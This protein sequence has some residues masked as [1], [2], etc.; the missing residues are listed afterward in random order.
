[1]K[2]TIDYDPF[3]G[4][5][6]SHDYDH[7]SGKTLIFQEQDVERI[8][9]QNKA[10]QLSGKNTNKGDYKHF[11]RVPL[12]VLLEWKEKHGVDWNKAEDLPKIERLL[13]SNEYRFLRTADR[14]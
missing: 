5:K 14:I 9:K 11:A 8:L 7:S 1:M 3:T 13:S 6:T 12:T 4:I 10:D 2:R